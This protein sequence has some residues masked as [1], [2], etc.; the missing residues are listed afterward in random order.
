M[1]LMMGEVLHFSRVAK[2][3]PDSA[4]WK[5]LAFH[6]SH[7]EWTGCSV[8]D[9][10]Q[11]SF[12]FLVGVALP[13]S[14]ASR[15]RRGETLGFATLHAAWRALLLIALGIALRS[16]GRSQTNYTF[17]DTLTQ[18][19]LGYFPLFL[20]G[21]ARPRV[22]WIALGVILV[23]YWA[24]FA[25]HPLP[26]SDFDYAAV[27]VKSDW[28]HLAPGFAAH[29]NKNSNLAW[30]FDRW[31]LNQF[32]REKPFTHN[33]GGYATLSFIPTL[34]T[35]LL[36]LIAGGWIQ[37]QGRAAGKLGRMLL[38]GVV[39]IA[40]GLALQWLGVCPIVKRIWTPSWVLFSGGICFVVLGVLYALIDLTGY[41]GWTYPLRVIGRNSIAAYCIAHLIEDFLLSSFRTHLGKDF[42]RFAGDPYQPLLTGGAVLLVYWL[43]LFW[44]DRRKIYLKV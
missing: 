10:I 16:I 23:G 27:G 8:H 39:G 44:M 32:P 11:P 4:L 26:G 21:L 25:F 41:T 36:G 3:L 40:L 22:R 37:G 18:I 17:E 1:L 15:L 31:F 35:M 24:A 9:M 14:L 2:A 6:Q 7:V 20:I 13:F 33:G 30:E 43:I 5:T 12:S 38:A 19:G 28:G 42:F 34:G 29:W